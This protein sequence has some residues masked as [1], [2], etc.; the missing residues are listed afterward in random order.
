M[1]N[2]EKLRGPG[3][4][5]NSMHKIVLHGADGCLM[6]LEPLDWKRVA[7]SSGLWSPESERCLD[8]TSRKNCGMWPGMHF[9]DL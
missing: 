5:L 1:Y 2:S 3:D 7:I 4:R 8:R 6:G 9:L